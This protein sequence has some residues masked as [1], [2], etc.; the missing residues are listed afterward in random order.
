[1]RL[2][3][4]YLGNLL[5]EFGGNAAHAVAA[6]N[7]GPD[8]VRRWI[9]ERPGLELDQWVE[10]IPYA[11]TREYVKHVLASYEAYQQVYASTERV[12]ASEP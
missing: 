4:A 8:A 7:A 1:L 11:E 6:Y 3:A 10:E 2:G 5:G 12:A 9:R